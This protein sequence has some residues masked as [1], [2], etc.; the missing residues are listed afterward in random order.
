MPTVARFGPY[1]V[2]FYSADRAEPPHAHVEHETRVAKF[3][4]DPVRLATSGGFKPAELGRIR[5]ML[6]RRERA[7]VEAWNGYFGR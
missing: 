7:L 2:F 4:L 5:G 6:I 3:W 1:R